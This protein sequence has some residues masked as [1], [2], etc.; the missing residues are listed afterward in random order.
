VTVLLHEVHRVRGLHEDRFEELYRDEWMRLLSEGD[1]GRLLWYLHQ[2]HGTGFAYNIITITALQDGAAWE[3]V[4]RRVQTGDLQ[5][6]AQE[7]D[8]CRH[9]VVAKLLFPLEWSP[10]NEVDLATVPT[11]PAADH[12]L[13]LYMEDTGW[14]HKTVDEYVA[15]WRQIY[16]PLIQANEA[17]RN[18][19]RLLDIQAVFQVAHGAGRRPEAILMQ[20]VVDHQALLR[21]FETETP[22]EMR[23]PGT[24]MHE[25]L[26]VRDQWESRLL[27]TS[28][29]SPLY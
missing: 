21:L 9:D 27:R 4:A 19:P 10:L 3:R 11:D 18:R 23:A 15:M 8:A 29:W 24:F 6:W 22:P 26:K 5:K 17:D 7:V 25:A 1:D 13:S 12:E 2:A 20:K 28:K 16:W 14:P